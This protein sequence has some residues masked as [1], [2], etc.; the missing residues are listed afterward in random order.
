[1]A[2]A[3][4]SQDAASQTLAAAVEAPASPQEADRWLRLQSHYWRQLYQADSPPQAIPAPSTTPADAADAAQ[5]SPAGIPW[6]P[7]RVLDLCA[8]PG[9]KSL[10]L[11]SWLH[12]DSVIVACEVDGLRSAV[13]KE[14]VE[15]GGAG[16]AEAL[17]I[18]AKIDDLLERADM[19]RKWKISSMQDDSDDK[20][21]GGDRRRMAVE[22]G[23][24]AYPVDSTSYFDTNTGKST[25]QAN[26]TPKIGL[27]GFFDLILIDAPCSGSAMFRK[28]ANTVSAWSPGLVED[29]RKTQRQLIQSVCTLLQSPGG[30]L[31]YMTCSFDEAENSRQVAWALSQVPALPSSSNASGSDTLTEVSSAAT[32]AAPDSSPRLQPSPLRQLQA[33]PEWGFLP[34]P[35]PT[36][37]AGHEAGQPQSQ[38]EAKAGK[39]KAK[40]K[41][42]KAAVLEAVE[43]VDSD[44]QFY[45]TGLPQYQRLVRVIS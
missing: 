35:G 34:G 40:G 30:R 28:D 17:V 23:L 45:A 4:Y 29:V 37:G 9:G 21:H 41:K 31:V 25:D 11:R 32:T 26:S 14:N 27:S 24:R 7:L 20:A 36:S 8:A 22:D 44:V 18:R 6:R 38:D 19:E 43:S 15:R 42:G 1:M 13:L 16:G 39:A 12:P 3:Y 5:S 10:L 33:H 2:G